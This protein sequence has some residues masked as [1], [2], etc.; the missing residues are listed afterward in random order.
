MNFEA[1]IQQIL[2]QADIAQNLQHY[3][4]GN[5]E[6]FV[7]LI[8]PWVDRFVATS[9]AGDRKDLFNA[10]KKVTNNKLQIIFDSRNYKEWKLEE[11]RF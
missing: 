9:N 11:V 10:I 4:K 6:N 8:Q 5:K 2:K 3:W 7:K 1:I